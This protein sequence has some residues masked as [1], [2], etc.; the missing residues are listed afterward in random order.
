MGDRVN[1]SIVEGGKRLAKSV[2]AETAAAAYEWN[3]E[4]SAT[5]ARNGFLE[6]S[7]IADLEAR[8]FAVYVE[9]DGNT[10]RM[11]DGVPLKVALTPASKSAR[12]YVSG[13]PKVALSKSLEGLRAV[14]AGAMLQVG[15][16]AGE[17]LAGSAVRVD[18][19][20][21]KGNVVR[22]AGAQA[23]NGTNQVSLDAPKPGIYMLRVRAGSQMRAGRILVK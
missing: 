5:S 14:Q 10:T 3:V 19:L 9:V 23:L 12:V 13:T 18:V 7:G 17:G 4:L 15:F 11:Q 8:G 16:V 6:I 1:L 2:K 22:S 21:L 20:D